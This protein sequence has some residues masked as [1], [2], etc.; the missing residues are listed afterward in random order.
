MKNKGF[1]LVELLAV[2]IILSLILFIVAPNVLKMIERGKKQ[3]F[4][5]D[6]EE[7]ISIAKYKSKLDKYQS[8]FV[9][10]GGDCYVISMSDLGFEKTEDADGNEYDQ[11]HSSVKYCLEN[12]RQVFYVTLI[13]TGAGGNGMSI[14]N[15]KE[16]NLSIQSVTS[17]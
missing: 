15:V 1:T 6:A 11:S 16:A 12:S 5:A 17:N 8:L 7:M 13:S 2:L 9:N 14:N 4:L 10:S 3:R